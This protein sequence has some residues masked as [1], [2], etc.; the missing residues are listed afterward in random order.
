MAGNTWRCLETFLAVR[1][2]GVAAGTEWVGAS[3]AAPYP[4]SSGPPPQRPPQPQISIQWGPVGKACLGT[5]RSKWGSQTRRGSLWLLGRGRPQGGPPEGADGGLVLGPA[6]SRLQS[7]WPI[8]GSMKNP[9]ALPS[10][11][12][13]QRPSW[14]TGEQA[15]AS[16]LLQEGLSSHA[17]PRSGRRGS[18]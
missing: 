10:P 16:C 12:Q 8:Q 14:G 3:D 7:T 1:T 17:T 15:G 5:D 4:P 2:Q 11:I 6:H 9:R 18:P 13:P